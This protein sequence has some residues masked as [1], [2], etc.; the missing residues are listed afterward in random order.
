MYLPVRDFD[1]NDLVNCRP[2]EHLFL[3]PFIAKICLLVRWLIP[4]NRC[5]GGDDL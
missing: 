2:D 3:I 4:M 5:I 1:N